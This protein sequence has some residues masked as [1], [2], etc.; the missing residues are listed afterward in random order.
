MSHGDTYPER[1]LF[2]LETKSSRIWHR[3]F[4]N[5]SPGSECSC[6][7]I[8]HHS[9]SQRKND[10]H[11]GPTSF[12]HLQLPEPL[13]PPPARFSVVICTCRGVASPLSIALPLP[14]PIVWARVTPK[15]ILIKD[16]L[17]LEHELQVPQRTARRVLALLRRM[18]RPLMTI[19]EE[20]I[21]ANIISGAENEGEERAR[22]KSG[23]Y[24][25]TAAVGE[26]GVASAPR[27]VENRM[28]CRRLRRHK[29]HR[30]RYYVRN[31]AIQ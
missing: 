30:P 4:S 27:R 16:G 14:R 9:A 8:R 12:N 2:I 20:N 7:V 10:M 3:P 5:F 26:V 31:W 17:E 15:H 22:D 19:Y 1:L 25:Q 23:A 21:Q 13:K 11:I 28:V 24:L 6:K 18:N 29:L